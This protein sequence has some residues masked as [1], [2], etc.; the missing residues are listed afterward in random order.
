MFKKWIALML[1]LA[2]VLSVL[3]FAAFAEQVA[4]EATVAPTEATIEPGTEQPTPP[5]EPKEEEKPKPKLEPLSPAQAAIPTNKLPTKASRIARLR[6]LIQWDYQNALEQEDR[7]S[8]YGFCGLLASYQMFYRGI[9]SWRLCYDGKDNFDAFSKMGM[10]DGG[11]TIRSYPALKEP[12]PTEQPTE[13]PETTPAEPEQAEQPATTE[14]ETVPQETPQTPE[15]APAEPEK[16]TIAEILNK[17]TNNG[18]KE[19][20]NLLVCFEKTNTAAG[21]IYGHVLFVYGIIDGTVYF[22]EGGNMF[23]VEAG[24]PMECSIA[25]FSASYATWTDFEG[26][27]VFGNKDYLDNCTVRTC[28]MFATCT[29]NVPLLPLPD[30][31]ENGTVQ[32]TA[33]RG[34][35]LQVV[36]LYQNRD[37]EYYYEIYDGGKICY[38]PTDGM[39][40]LLFLH[41]PYNTEELVLPQVLEAG[42]DFRLDGKVRTDNY[43]SQIQ[44][45]I[46]DDQG[47]ILQR[48]TKPVGDSQYDLDDWNLN[49]ELDFAVL[50][51]GIYTLKVEATASN[52][53]LY[54]GYRA[55]NLHQEIVA[56]QLFAVGKDVQLPV[57]A[58]ELPAQPVKDGWVYE[59]RTW[60]C[61]DKGM[62]VTGWRQEAGAWYYL[63][64]D[65][66]VSTDWTLVD[67]Q[68][69][70]FTDTGAMRTG[71]VS[72]K[73]GRQYLLP[74]GNMVRGWLQVDGEYHYFDALGVLRED[75]MRTTMDRMAQL[76][77]ALY[78]PAPQE[79]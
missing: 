46:L 56:E 65:G 30:L 62:P 61:F 9:N 78:A 42:R 48:Y 34:E 36:G 7:E 72:T 51:E 52:W 14:P 19:V 49:W 32:R 44:I 58:K 79:E 31:I 3:P 39:E 73:M 21:T 50:P 25:Q 5:E 15:A 66:S 64:A 77:K 4:T 68:L 67:G 11:Y 47:N 35:R 40:A 12:E 55:K 1:A 54:R 2:T 70:L 8:L 33:T 60:Y 22:T 27:I 23:G 18:S 63:Q 74:N 20:Y 38:A 29:Q 16:Y 6:Y 45:S 37:G 24:E 69:K 43:M 17:V 75:H 13:T 57:M 28:N 41:E 59:N 71:W 10:T 76:D 26:V 53:Y